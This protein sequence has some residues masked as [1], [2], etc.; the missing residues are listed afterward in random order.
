MIHDVGPPSQSLD[1]AFVLLDW[2]QIKRGSNTIMVV[3]IEGRSTF[4]IKK[5]TV[6][7][8]DAW[9]QRVDSNIIIRFP[10]G[11][12]KVDS[13]GNVRSPQRTDRCISVNPKAT[14]KD[15]AGLEQQFVRQSFANGY[16]LVDGVV[17]NAENPALFHVPPEVLKRNIQVGFY[18]EIRIDSERFSIHDEAAEVCSCPSCQGEMSKPIFRHLHP[19][20]IVPVPPQEVPA[21]GW[22]EDFWVRVEEKMGE[23]FKGIV[24]NPLVESRL[25]EVQQHDAIIFRERHVLAIHDIHRRELVQGMTPEDVKEFATWL[26]TQ[27]RP[28]DERPF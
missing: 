24:D 28:D 19:A 20:S 17:M 11:L 22:G 6:R 1:N 16:D 3:A 12:S 14:W 8:A 5:K 21:R 27:H 18:V 25:H 10:T 9:N 13:P 15:M 2:L 7:A 23:Y 26:S 4:G